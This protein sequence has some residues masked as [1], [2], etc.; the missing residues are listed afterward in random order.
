[1]CREGNLV[2]DERAEFFHAASARSNIG[3]A[4][5]ST[6]PISTEELR[7]R[8]ERIFPDL[9]QYLADS[10]F[11]PED[12]IYTPHRLCSEFT[13]FYLE[14][15]TD[16]DSREVAELFRVM[17]VI[18]AADPIGYYPIA[19]AVFTCFLENISCTNAGEAG[20]ALMGPVSYEFFENWHRPPPYKR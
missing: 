14:R 3:R 7:L 18:V 19:N 4:G 10:F 2:P 1:L 13:S 5:L 16:F 8:L 9:G 6:I 11:A 20:R 15:I 17:E 12:G